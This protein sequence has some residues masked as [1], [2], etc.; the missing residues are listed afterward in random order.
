MVE[1][2]FDLLT[3]A[4]SGLVALSC[5]HV[6][7]TLLLLL[8]VLAQAACRPTEPTV[9][10]TAQQIKLANG[11]AQQHSRP[12]QLR[13]TVTYYDPAWQILMV[14]DETGGLYIN[15]QEAVLAEESGTAL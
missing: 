9:Y 10:T 12:V 13:A 8:L 14:Q 1:R 5:R 2:Y 4:L 6:Q 11:D 7:I 15:P 3:L